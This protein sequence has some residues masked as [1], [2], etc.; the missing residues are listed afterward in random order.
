MLLVID[1][2]RGIQTQTAECLVLGEML[3]QRLI[4]CVNKCGPTDVRASSR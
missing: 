4:V 3:V 1:A 2:Q